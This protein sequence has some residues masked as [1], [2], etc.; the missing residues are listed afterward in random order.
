M[1]KYIEVFKFN[2]K[3]KLNFKVEYIFSLF[4]FTIHVF[5]FNELW[6]FILKDKVILEYSRCELIWYI[7][8]GEFL[9]YVLGSK[10]YK[11]ISN[12]IKSGDVANMLTKPISFLKYIISIEL[13]CIVNVVVNF[14]FA[15][16]LGIFM[17]GKLKVCFIQVVLFAISLIFSLCLLILIQVMIG[18]LA[19]ITEEN[20]AYRLVIFKSILLLILTP[21]E[22]FPNMVKNFLT[23]LPTTYAIYPPGRILVHFELKNSLTLLICQAVSLV[24][25]LTIVNLL[26][27]K[28]VKNINVNGG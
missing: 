11:E 12:M 4:S 16:F 9:Y 5:V 24:V 8:I 20:E 17:A 27:L 19:F 1:R 10:N 25:L 21:L 13:T 6:D 7:L 22:F 3:T 26:N 14:G 28:G 18:M 2:L 15:I 23:F